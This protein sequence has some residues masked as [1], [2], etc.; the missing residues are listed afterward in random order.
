MERTP[1]IEI[2]DLSSDCESLSYKKSSPYTKR[3][4]SKKSRQ[5]KYVNMINECQWE[6]KKTQRNK[7]L[8]TAWRDTEYPYSIRNK[9]K[10]IS[11]YNFETLVSQN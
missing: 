6:K 5:C 10:C 7:I 1:N 11:A 9:C 8:Q 4:V 3:S 2:I